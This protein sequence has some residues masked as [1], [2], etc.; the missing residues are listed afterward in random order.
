MSVGVAEVKGLRVVHCFRFF[1]RTDQRAQCFG[2]K[3][4]N[5]HLQNDVRTADKYI[6]NW[7]EPERA[8]H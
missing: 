5:L 1:A 7:G 6:Y 4:L 2:L 3:E 8:P